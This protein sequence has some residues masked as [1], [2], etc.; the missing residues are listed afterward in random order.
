MK[1]EDNFFFVL[2]VLFFPLSIFIIGIAHMV[3]NLIETLVRSTNKRASKAIG[4][5]ASKVIEYILYN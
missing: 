5:F 4:N 1:N 3:A 2:A